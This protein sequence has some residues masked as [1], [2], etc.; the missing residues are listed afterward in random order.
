MISRIL[1]SQAGRLAGRGIVGAGTLLA[2]V[3]AATEVDLFEGK[4]TSPLTF[5]TV[6][7]VA[8]VASF[9]LLGGVFSPAYVPVRIY[10]LTK[11]S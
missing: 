5:P 4:R 10:Q 9:A 3:E 1:S 2:G 6:L 11:P 8:I 7:K